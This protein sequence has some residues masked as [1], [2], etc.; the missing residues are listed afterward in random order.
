MIA[1]V[2]LD[3]AMPATPQ[4]ARE[5]GAAAAGALDPEPVDPAK[6][7]SPLLELGVTASVGRDR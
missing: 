1:P 4:K 3:D 2:D 7:P 5:P 6:R